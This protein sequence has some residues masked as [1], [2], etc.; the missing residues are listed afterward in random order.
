MRWVCLGA[1]WLLLV[2]PAAAAQQPVS[3]CSRECRPTDADVNGIVPRTQAPVKVI[4]YGHPETKVWE[5]IALTAQPPESLF[6]ED[7]KDGYLMPRLRLRLG[8]PADINFDGN[9]VV[10]QQ[11]NYLHSYHK[12][13]TL[14]TYSGDPRLVRDLHVVGP[15]ATGYFYLSPTIARGQLSGV[16]APAVIPGLYA[17]MTVESGYGHKVYASGR[18]PPAV[19]VGQ[20]GAEPVYELS[21]PMQVHETVWSGD[22]ALRGFLWRVVLKQG[23]AGPFEFAQSD[24]VMRSGPHFPPRLVLT[25]ANPL[26]LGVAQAQYYDHHTYA[27]FEVFSPFGAYDVSPEDARLDVE[28]PSPVPSEFVHFVMAKRSMDHDGTFKPVKFIWKIDFEG[29]NAAPGVYR[30]T[31][32]VLNGQGTFEAVSSTL[33]TLYAWDGEFETVPTAGAWAPLVGL[34]TVAFFR[35]RA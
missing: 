11:V 25:V 23:E 8:T 21:V 26:E 20:I 16:S 29:A 32:H 30:V 14:R 7:L 31:A 19:L 18:G 27:R 12:D 4:L 6:D 33:T 34:L 22:S 5:Q 2:L 15:T 13:N 10:F 9:R 3:G 35:R 24:W 1:L 28:G 17:E